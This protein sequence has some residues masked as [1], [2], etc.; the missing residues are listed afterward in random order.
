MSK[1]EGVDYFIFFFFFFPA[2]KDKSTLMATKFVGQLREAICLCGWYT[3]AL[4]R[5]RTAVEQKFQDKA[6]SR[7]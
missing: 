2:F 7:G 1:V 6:L 5:A 3:Q 4:Q